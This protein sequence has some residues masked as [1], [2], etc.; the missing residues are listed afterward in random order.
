MTTRK[1]TH[2]R[3]LPGGILDQPAASAPAGFEAGPAPLPAQRDDVPFERRLRAAILVAA[4]GHLLI[5]EECALGAPPAILDAFEHDG[6][7]RDEALCFVDMLLNIL[8]PLDDE[9]ALR[10]VA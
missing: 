5:P 8:Q 1:R 9:T 6:L 3:L 7:L 4:I 10:R 2:L